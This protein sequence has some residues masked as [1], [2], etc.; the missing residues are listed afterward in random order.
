M[1]VGIWINSSNFPLSPIHS[2]V[3]RKAGFPPTSIKL[4]PLTNDTKLLGSGLRTPPSDEMST[5]FQPQLASYDS[6]AMHNYPAAVPQAARA[7]T[8][9]NDTRGAQYY[10]YAAAQTQQSQ[11]QQQQPQTHYSHYPYQQQQATH[12]QQEPHSVAH[13]SQSRNGSVSSATQSICSSRQ[14]LRPLSP[15][16]ASTITRSKDETE[17]LVSHSL[18][19]PKCISPAGGNLSDFAAKVGLFLPSI[20]LLG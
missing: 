4:P 2:T 17:S 7:T 6:H 5:A 18:Q 15:S 20:Y 16:S 8:A 14:T 3:G 9:M 12:L 1:S 19:I 13:V 10:R 11:S